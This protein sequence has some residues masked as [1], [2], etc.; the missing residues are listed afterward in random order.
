MFGFKR[1]ARFV[2]VN[3]TAGPDPRKFT[4]DLW[5][6][7]RQDWCL[8]FLD[9]DFQEKHPNHSI[10]QPYLQP[11]LAWPAYTQDTD[12]N[13][14]RVKNGQKSYPVPLINHFP[15]LIHGRIRGTIVAVRPQAFI[16]LDKHRLN[17]LVFLRFRQTFLVPYR[18]RVISSIGEIKSDEQVQ[19]VRAWMYMGLPKFWDTKIDG[20]YSFQQV[21]HFQFNP[22]PWKWNPGVYFN[23]TLN[24]Y[25]QDSSETHS[26][27]EL[28]VE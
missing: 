28:P 11:G 14:W 24:E 13:M 20:G 3:L 4:P 8:L 10:I 7:E 5:Q 16:Q 22:K 6:L 19:H 2:D 17:R 21:Q 15:R 25:V 26:L 12:W 23:F 1:K 18:N 9:D 27:P